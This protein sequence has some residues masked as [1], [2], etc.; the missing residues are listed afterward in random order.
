ML[1]KDVQNVTKHSL[2]FGSDYEHQDEDDN[3][4]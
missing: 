3:I 2:R 4:F 1:G